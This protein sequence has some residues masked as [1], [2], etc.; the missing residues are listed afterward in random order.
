MTADP[1]N[2]QSAY[3]RKPAS[4]TAPLAPS[5]ATSSGPIAG[6]AQQ[7]AAAAAVNAE[8]PA[9]AAPPAVWA[10]RAGP[11]TDE[12]TSRRDSRAG[13]D[14][15]GVMPDKVAHERYNFLQT[16]IRDRIRNPSSICLRRNKAAPAQAR[17]MIR[18][19]ALRAAQN[20]YDLGHRQRPFDQQIQDSQ[21]SRVAKR[22]EVLG[23]KFSRDR[24]GLLRLHFT[25]LCHIV[26]LTYQ[27]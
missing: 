3:G 5:V 17:E 12:R 18:H 11:F 23:A 22:S 10:E 24:E 26:A 1:S 2:I 27:D 13:R 15:L 21:A 19:A 7:T 6:P 9:N 8:P 25:H 20:I 16:C 14:M 4:A